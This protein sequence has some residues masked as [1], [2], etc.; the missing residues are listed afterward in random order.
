MSSYCKKEIWLVNYHIVTILSEFN[1]KSSLQQCFYNSAKMLKI[2][3]LKILLWKK[4][5]TILNRKTTLQEISIV[6][7]ALFED[8]VQILSWWEDKLLSI[9]KTIKPSI[10]N[11][12]MIK[13]DESILNSSRRIEVRSLRTGCEIFITRDICGSRFNNFLMSS[14][15]NLKKPCFQ[16]NVYIYVW[17]I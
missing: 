15:Q 16:N 1:H 13:T 6:C 11:I 7:W 14:L 8:S 12:S 5:D 10:F 4:S 9:S 2:Y 3:Y 17:S